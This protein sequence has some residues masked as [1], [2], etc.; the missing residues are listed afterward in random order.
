M[1]D[2]S[3]EEPS[4]VEGSCLVAPLVALLAATLDHPVE[5]ADPSVAA[6]LSILGLQ[7]ETAPDVAET[8]VG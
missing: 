7:G 1:V 5:D 3:A 2:D 8:S 4:A 6:H